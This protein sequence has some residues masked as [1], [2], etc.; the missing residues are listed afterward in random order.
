[1][2]LEKC[3][4]LEKCVCTN[5][6]GACVNQGKRNGVPMKIAEAVPHN[7][8]NIWCVAHKLGLAM[9]DVIKVSS[10]V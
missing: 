1:M 10:N 2:T 9:L 8:V 5:M 3:I 7:V 4:C 6:D